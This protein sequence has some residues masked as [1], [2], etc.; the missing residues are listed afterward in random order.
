[1]DDGA[2]E[3][4]VLWAN[5]TA[6]RGSTSDAGDQVVAAAERRGHAVERV[7]LDSLPAA[8]EATRSM[9]AEGVDRLVVVGGDGTVHQG[10]QHVAGTDIAFGVVPAGSGNDFAAAMGVPSDVPSAVVRA[11]D[12]VDPVDLIRVGDRYGA[13][14][15]TIGMSVEVT[16]RADR[17]WWPRGP[18]KYTVATLLELP[19]LRTYP[20]RLVVDGVEHHVAPNLVGFANTPTFGGGMRIAP[21][22]DARDGMLDVVLIGPSSRRAM[23]RLLAQAGAGGHLGH[24]D[25]RVLRGARVDVEADEPFRVDV[26]GEAV[27]QAPVTIEVVPGALRLA[28]G[29]SGVH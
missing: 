10:L 6:G 11:L 8:T 16:I 27:G 21:G 13:T 29:A 12:D 1:M 3:R 28:G 14:V 25:V 18:A 23:L 15:A 24:P 2:R 22:A 20:M 5:P 9:I 19:R 17:L 4:I 7:P 26:D